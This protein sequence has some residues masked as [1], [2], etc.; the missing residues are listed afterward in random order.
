MA[1]SK[2]SRKEH[3]EWVEDR[4]LT[5]L[6]VSMMAGPHPPGRDL[7]P[8]SF[9]AEYIDGKYDLTYTPEEIGD[10]YWVARRRS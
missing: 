1:S 2:Q 4:W 6:V 5:R 10:I 7:C 3:G 8:E 9:I